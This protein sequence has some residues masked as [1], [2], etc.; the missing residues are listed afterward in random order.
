LT[1]TQAPIDKVTRNTSLLRKSFYGAA[2]YHQKRW[3]VQMK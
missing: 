3:D 1:Y 2:R